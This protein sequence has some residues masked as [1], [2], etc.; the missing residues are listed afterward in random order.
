MAGSTGSGFFFDLWEWVPFTVDWWL[1]DAE[2]GVAAEPEFIVVGGG[3]TGPVGEGLGGASF[4][5]D[6]DRCALAVLAPFMFASNSEDPKTFSTQNQK[7]MDENK[8][9]AQQ[10]V[11][12]SKSTDSL[13]LAKPTVNTVGSSRDN[14]YLCTSRLYTQRILFIVQAASPHF[15][16]RRGSSGCY[17]LDPSEAFS[18]KATSSGV[19]ISLSHK[20]ATEGIQRD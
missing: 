1:E 12:G 19:G 7:Q 3:G 11:R 9:G 10:Q 13:P 14:F 2:L 15:R 8:G 5:P 17:P 4:E 20:S 18:P 6:A 16:I